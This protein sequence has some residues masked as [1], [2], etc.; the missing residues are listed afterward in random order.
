MK[1]M[2]IP[3]MV[4][5]GTLSVAVGQVKENPKLPFDAGVGC[6]NVTNKLNATIF[7]LL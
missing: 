5:L 6:V 7:H 2:V 4:A 3:A 1:K